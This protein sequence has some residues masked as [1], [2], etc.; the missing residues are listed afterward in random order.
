VKGIN[1]LSCLARYGDLSLPVGFE[2][3]HKDLHFCDIKS[4]KEVKKACVTKNELARGLIKQA[5]TNQVF[6]EYVLADNWFCSKETM[7]FIHYE[8]KKKFIFG[9]KSNRLVAL[10]DETGKRGQYQSLNQLDIKDGETL[11]ISLKNFSVPLTLIKKIFKNEDDSEGTLYLVTNDLEKDAD[12]IYEVYQK[13]WHIEQYHKSIKQNSSLEKSPTKALRA[14]KNH[15]FASIIGYCKL[16]YLKIG[17]A[18][19]HLALKYKLIIRANQ[20]A[21][22]ELKKLRHSIPCVR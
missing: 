19:N 8:I 7:S 3:V 10:L 1:L 20:A 16:E 18:L 14:Q 9:L 4:R 15:L 11:K 6:F 5:T 12:R 21:Y 17:T 22:E 2:I 13:R